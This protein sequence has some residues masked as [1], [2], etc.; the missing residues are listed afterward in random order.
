VEVGIP[1][2]LVAPKTTEVSNNDSHLEAECLDAE[3]VDGEIQVTLIQGLPC[4]GIDTTL[5]CAATMTVGELARIIR[6]AFEFRQWL[7]HE[8]PSFS[9]CPVNHASP[10]AEGA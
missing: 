7:R 10:P 8:I 3:E 9:A 1:T 6:K 4:C 2:Q 5:E